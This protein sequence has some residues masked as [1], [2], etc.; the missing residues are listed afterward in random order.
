[1]MRS[2]AEIKHQICHHYETDGT[3]NLTKIG[4]WLKWCLGGDHKTYNPTTHQLAKIDD[5][6]VSSNFDDENTDPFEGKT[7]KIGYYNKRTHKVVQIEEPWVKLEKGQ[8]VVNA[9]ALKTT[10]VVVDRG[11]LS[12]ILLVANHGLTEIAPYTKELKQACEVRDNLTKS[13][14]G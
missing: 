3:N 1:M 14:E 11:D 6:L 7:D 12:R 2:E 13:L 4:K 10:Q 8:I 5:I 9:S